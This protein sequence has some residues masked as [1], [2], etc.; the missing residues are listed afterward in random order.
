MSDKNNWRYNSTFTV[1]IEG[2][3]KDRVWKKAESIDTSFSDYIRESLTNSILPEEL[4]QQLSP[5]CRARVEKLA[6]H[7]DER[8]GKVL[9][10]RLMNN[11]ISYYLDHVYHGV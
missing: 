4:L 7:M 5:E 10:E 8:P 3:I 11:A 2:D 9:I 1:R 6:K